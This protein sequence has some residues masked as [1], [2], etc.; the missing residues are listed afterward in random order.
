MTIRRVEDEVLLE[1]VCTIED[2]ELLLQHLQDGASRLDWSG[3]THLHSAC[4]QVVLSA[5][6]PMHGTPLG[7]ELAR[8]LT[9]LVDADASSI[10]RGMPVDLPSAN[11]VEA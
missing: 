2:A 1:G 8:W 9:P 6:L 4:F 11:C 3:C 10:R 5:H 7:P